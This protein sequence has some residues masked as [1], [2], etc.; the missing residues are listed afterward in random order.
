MTDNV[1]TLN[2]RFRT[3]SGPPI[4][5]Q[6]LLAPPVNAPSVSHAEHYLTRPLQQTLVKLWLLMSRA[7]DGKV[8]SWVALTQPECDA[9]TSK[10]WSDGHV[11]LAARLVRQVLTEGD[12]LAT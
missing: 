2:K 4:P 6:K 1:V 5:G 12:N 3:K 8:C 9:L 7:P 11:V 10:L